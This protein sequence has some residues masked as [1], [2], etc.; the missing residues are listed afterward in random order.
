[1]YTVTGVVPDTTVS[2]CT[3]KPSRN[4]DWTTVAHC[5]TFTTEAGCAASGVGELLR[6]NDACTSG[7]SINVHASGKTYNQCLALAIADGAIS[8]THDATNSA[9]KTFSTACSAGAAASGIHTYTLN[10]YCGWNYA[11]EES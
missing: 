3:H 6:R 4:G 11:Y 1:M 10:H 7:T 8:F 9:C 5:K 2:K